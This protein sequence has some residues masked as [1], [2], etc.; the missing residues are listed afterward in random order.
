MLE[1]IEKLKKRTM[2]AR[3]LSKLNADSDLICKIGDRIGETS[4]KNLDTQKNENAQYTETAVESKMLKVALS[5]CET[6]IAVAKS[7]A[8]NMLKSKLPNIGYNILQPH[9][10]YGKYGV[11][12]SIIERNSTGRVERG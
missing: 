10:Q 11:V 5:A 3:V 7:T 8:T 2:E 12:R 4:Q 9:E 6:N 1:H